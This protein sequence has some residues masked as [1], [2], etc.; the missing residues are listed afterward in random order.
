ML[1]RPA[2]TNTP[3]NHDG[4]L[5]VLISLASLA[6][7]VV[8]I[9]AAVFSI[10]N[11]TASERRAA[12]RQLLSAKISELGDCLFSELAQCNTYVNRNFNHDHWITDAKNTADRIQKLRT[13]LRYPLWGIDNPLKQLSR[14]AGRIQHFKNRSIHDAK[15]YLEAANSLRDAL[16]DAI[17]YSYE[18]GKPPSSRKV[19]AARVAADKLSA[20]YSEWLPDNSIELDS[21]TESHS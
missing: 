4:K 13:E 16:D 8:S 5:T 3:I 2:N 7:S 6:T 9:L 20:I 18:H 1:N 12:Y 19:N 21:E 11:A 14:V 15:R 17:K 10:W